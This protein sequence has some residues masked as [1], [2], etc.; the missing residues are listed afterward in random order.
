MQFYSLGKLHKWVHKKVYSSKLNSPLCVSKKKHM[1]YLF[2]EPVQVA[3]WSHIHHHPSGVC[4]DWTK[5]VEN[6]YQIVVENIS[7][8]FWL[9]SRKN[10]CK[11]LN[12]ESLLL[13]LPT[14][15]IIWHVFTR[16]VIMSPVHGVST[17]TKYDKWSYKSKKMGTGHVFYMATHSHAAE[18]VLR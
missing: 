12:E 4:L 16:P 14:Y 7:F 8:R 10:S 5:V 3:R 6:S 9:H 15:S 2:F 13:S 18:S 17:V 1:S 11:Q